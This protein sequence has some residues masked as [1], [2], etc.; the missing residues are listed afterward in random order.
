M[1]LVLLVRS[2]LFLLASLPI[3]VLWQRSNRELLLNLGFALF[4][5]VGFLYMLGAYYMP[6]E[7]R[8]PHTLEIL[9]SSFAY[10]GLLV[11]LLASGKACSVKT[12]KAPAIS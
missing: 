9:A 8:V 3:V 11:V 6:L 10:S 5:L 7:I 1:L 12:L 4:V 2:I